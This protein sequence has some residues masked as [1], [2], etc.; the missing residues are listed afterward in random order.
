M[1]R[2]LKY[3]TVPIKECMRNKM[4][5]EAEVIVLSGQRKRVRGSHMKKQR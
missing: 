1:L 5:E 4:R 2:T 3:I